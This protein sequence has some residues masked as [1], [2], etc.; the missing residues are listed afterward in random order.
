MADIGK[1][2]L[3][4]SLGFIFIYFGL[5]QLLF[6]EDWLQLIPEYFLNFI[7]DLNIEVNDILRSKIIFINGVFLIFLG[8]GFIGGIYMR[9][10]S[11]LGTI[12]LLN[13]SFFS[14]NLFKIEG[15]TTLGLAF[16][17]LALFFLGNDS[18]CLKE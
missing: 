4:L 11:F 2:L 6:Q 12:Y 5:Q 14:L 7:A 17:C 10:L 16:S 18:F 1:L 15:V 13:L 9:F 3:R 8:L